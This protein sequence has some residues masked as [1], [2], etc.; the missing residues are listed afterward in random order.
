MR[1]EGNYYKFEEA[2]KGMSLRQLQKYIENA[3]GYSGNP[4]RCKFMDYE[5]ACITEYN[6][7]GRETAQHY[8]SMNDN[9]WHRSPNAITMYGSW[10]NAK[11][12]FRTI[13][14]WILDVF[15]FRKK[16]FDK[17]TKFIQERKA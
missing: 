15:G 5:T 6:F 2:I 13:A 4:E 10:Q 8:F 16:E 3:G 9:Q 1:Y 17:Y 7:I 12:P 11:E 14:R